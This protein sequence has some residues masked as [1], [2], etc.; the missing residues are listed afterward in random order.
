MIDPNSPILLYR[1]ISVEPNEEDRIRDQILSNGIQAEGYDATRTY[2]LH[3]CLQS[4]IEAFDEACRLSLKNLVEQSEDSDSYPAFAACGDEAGGSY[5]AVEHN[6]SE[7]NGHTCP[8]VIKFTTEIKNVQVNYE[9]FLNLAMSAR[10][11][12]NGPLQGEYLEKFYGPKIRLYWKSIQ[13]G[14]QQ[15]AA[16]ALASQD[17]EVIEAHAQNQFALLGKRHVISA[18]EFLV[19]SPVPAKNIVSV[20]APGIFSFKHD[21]SLR[22][23]HDLG[24]RHYKGTV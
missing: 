24:T 15:I 12:G 7:E 10:S 13:R 11:V 2:V 18:S 8:L 9:S 16:V 21:F 23:L 20:S 3:C 1:G 4:Q 6:R 22:N 17:L 14:T 19:R 5:Y